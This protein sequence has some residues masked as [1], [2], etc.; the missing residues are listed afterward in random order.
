MKKVVEIQVPQKIPH[1]QTKNFR[2]K[3]PLS[4]ITNEILI[5]V[6]DFFF[7]SCKTNRF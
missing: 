3:S 4:Y 1:L 7:I 6:S 2:M 5:F